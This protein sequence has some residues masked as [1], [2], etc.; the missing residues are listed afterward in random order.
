LPTSHTTVADWLLQAF[1]DTKPRVAKRLSNTRSRLT[2]SFDGWTANSKVLDLLG[3]ICYY[4]DENNKRRAVVLGLRDT[5]GSHTGANMADHLLSILHDFQISNQIAYFM[6]DNATNN[7]KALA[8]LAGYLPPSVKLD[9]VKQ[10]L[11]CSGH[12]Y[13]LV[14]KAILYGV[15]SDCIE[16]ASQASQTMTSVSS[17]EAVT[18]NGDDAAK[19]TAWRKKGP[20]GKLHNTVIHIKENAARRLLF[21]SKQRNAAPASEDLEAMRMYRVVANG[22]IR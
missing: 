2:I 20:V 1:E 9:P 3:I 14:C 7:D 22:G 18:N 12:I 5:L 13:N 10:R 17:L 15:D 19:L 4:I 6:S 8:M 21:E 11:R 16:D